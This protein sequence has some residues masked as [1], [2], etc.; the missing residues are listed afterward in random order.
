MANL[1]CRWT[2]LS[3]TTPTLWTDVNNWIDVATGVAPAHV[4]GN[5]ADTD[6]ALFDTLLATGAGSP[7]GI[8]I[9]GA[10]GG[11]SEFRVGP[12]F[13]GTIASLAL[14]VTLKAACPLVTIE[15]TAAGD[16]YITGGGAGITLMNVLGSRMNLT[17]GGT[18]V[19]LNLWRGVVNLRVTATI[20]T[21]LY[22]GYINS[23]T[24]D[25]VLTIPVGATLTPASY[26]LDGGT[27]YCS[28][29]IATLN[30]NG[31]TWYQ[32]VGAVTT[33]N[34][35]SG[36]FFWNSGTITLATLRGG[37]L[38]ASMVEDARTLTGMVMYPGSTANLRCGRIGAITI[39]G[40]KITYYG[41]TLQLNVG[42]VVGP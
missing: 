41:G 14:P 4:P 13:N 1:T 20:T 21:L 16:M 17:I 28:V 9:S 30:L 33:L 10:A 36:T 31:A 25:V 27:I 38:D 24:G 40:T 35:T 42:Q 2:G 29:A 18:V 39:G 12:A 6:V 26:T 19:T 11:L 5:G 34:M 15:G 37:S 3:A 22:V 23:K 8:D 32:I 7:A